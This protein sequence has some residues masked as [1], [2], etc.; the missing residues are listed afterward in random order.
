MECTFR[1][2][3]YGRSFRERSLEY[4]R[5]TDHFC[6]YGPDGHLYSDTDLGRCRFLCGVNIH[7]NGDGESN[8]IHKCNDN[9]H[10]WRDRIY[11]NTS[12]RNQW[13][14]AFGNDL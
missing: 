11:G 12:K 1:Q 6:E 5:D 7:G 13:D 10:M 3:I 9:Y 14:C 8:A 2:W 4:H